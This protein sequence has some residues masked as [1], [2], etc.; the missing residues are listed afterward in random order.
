V[1]ARNG[2]KGIKRKRSRK[3]QKEDK[4][5]N[6]LKKRRKDLT[7]TP[8]V[9]QLL[10]QMLPEDPLMLIEWNNVG[11]GAASAINPAHTR[12]VLVQALVNAGAIDENN[13]HLY[14][15]FR[16]LAAFVD[17]RRAMPAWSHSPGPLICVAMGVGVV[18]PPIATV[19]LATKLNKK[20]QLNTE[21]IEFPFFQSI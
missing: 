21:L 9:R 11:L 6:V 16:N 5:T 18:P 13:A 4:F 20:G 19:I 2:T 10:K 12:A 3:D 7:V 15:S 14:F 1:S 17:S 8:V